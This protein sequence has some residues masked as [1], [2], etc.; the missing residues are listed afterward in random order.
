MKPKPI[1]A[2]GDTVKIIGADREFVV[3]G[4][5]KRRVTTRCDGL[6]YRYKLDHKGHECSQIEKYVTTPNAIS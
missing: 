3:T 6:Q 2:I 1:F 4:V 5:T